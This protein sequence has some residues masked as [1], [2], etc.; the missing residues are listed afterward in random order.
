MHIFPFQTILKSF[1]FGGGIPTSVKFQGREIK[2][3]GGQYLR[4]AC[5]HANGWP[6][7]FRKIA[8]FL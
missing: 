7:Y 6:D 8:S 3:Q 5:K 4:Y 1:F 2:S